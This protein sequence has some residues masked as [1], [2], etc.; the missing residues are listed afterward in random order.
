[1]LA[2]MFTSAGLAPMPSIDGHELSTPLIL[3]LPVFALERQASETATF[4]LF[5]AVTLNDAEPLQV[6]AGPVAE[7]VTE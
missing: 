4:E 7:T 6:P 3:T 5:P 2:P 1:M